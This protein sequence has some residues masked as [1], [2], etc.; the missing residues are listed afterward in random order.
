MDPER[1]EVRFEHGII[2]LPKEYIQRSTYPPIWFSWTYLFRNPPSSVWTYMPAEEVAKNVPGYAVNP[3]WHDS[4]PSKPHDGILEIGRNYIEIK[5][6]TPL[7]ISAL[8]RIELAAST[9]SYIDADI[10]LKRNDYADRLIVREPDTGYYRVY[11][12]TNPSKT[13]RLY[14]LQ[15]HRD[16]A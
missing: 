12:N 15:T 7:I 13:W 6:D 4:M 10:W 2:Y 16:M 8:N 14:T 1:T 11:S 9:T 3:P 5:E